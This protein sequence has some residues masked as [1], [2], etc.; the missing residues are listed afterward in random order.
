MK[1][2]RFELCTTPDVHVKDR[3]NGQRVLVVAPEYGNL[4]CLERPDGHGFT[5]LVAWMNSLTQED[6]ESEGLE[7]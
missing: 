4:V 2:D 3:L 5:A 7:T 6:L 1:I